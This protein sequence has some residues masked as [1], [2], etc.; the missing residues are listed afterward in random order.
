MIRIPGI[1][2]LSLL[3]LSTFL[4]AQSGPPPSWQ[5]IRTHQ[6]AALHLK[7]TLAKDHFFQGEKIDATLEFSNDDPKTTYNLWI[8]GPQPFATFHGQDAQGH[9]LVDPHQWEIEFGLN[10]NWVTVPHALGK[11][12][13]S[14]PVNE[15]FRFDQLGV[16]TIYAQSQVLPDTK[17][18]SAKSVPL[19]SDKTTIT[20]TPITPELEKQVIADA[21]S[22]IKLV[23]SPQGLDAPSSEGIDELKSLQTPGARA[24]LIKLMAYPHLV[25]P[26]AAGL[27]TAPDPA[28]EARHI[29]EAVQAGNLVLDVG[30]TNVYARLKTA[31]SRGDLKQFGEATRE[32]SVAQVKA[33]ESKGPLHAEALWV[34]YDWTGT[35]KDRRAVVEHQL[36]LSD[37]TA[38]FIFQYWGSFGGKDLLPLLRRVAEANGNNPNIKDLALTLLIKHGA[39]SDLDPLITSLESLH[40]QDLYPIVPSVHANQILASNHWHPTAAQRKRL[41]ALLASQPAP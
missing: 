34:A 39:P 11:Y 15:N 24:E 13:Q 8:G 35:D 6:P 41:K 33:T 18:P 19:V 38:N 25:W 5:D 4:W 12:T 23:G 37:A 10:G 30:G 36:E 31:S 29:L 2:L 14:L 20:I 27:E 9:E 32:I 16:Y 40:G 1:V 21:I 17:D 22:K 28:A 7:I 3:V 26:A